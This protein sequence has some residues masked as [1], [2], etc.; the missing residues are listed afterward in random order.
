MRIGKARLK[1]VLSKTGAAT[2]IEEACWGDVRQAGGELGADAALD[3]GCPVVGRRGALEGVAD[4]RLGWPEGCRRV[5]AFT[6]SGI[7]ALLR[8]NRPAGT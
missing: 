6:H 1:I 2:G 8:G 3:V 4:A 7:G 5:D